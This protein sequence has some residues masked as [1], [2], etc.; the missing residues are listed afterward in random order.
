MALISL[1][2]MSS[3]TVLTHSIFWA[4]WIMQIQ[5]IQTKTL[6]ARHLTCI[7][8]ECTRPI[9]KAPSLCLLMAQRVTPSCG[10]NCAALGALGERVACPGY[11]LIAYARSDSMCEP[12]A[13]AVRAGAARLLSRLPSLGYAGPS[14][15]VRLHCLARCPGTA[16]TPANLC[17]RLCWAPTMRS[18]IHGLPAVGSGS[19]SCCA[20]AGCATRVRPCSVGA[21]CGCA[22]PGIAPLA[23][24]TAGGCTP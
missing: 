11:G 14:S 16:G 9:P 1:H 8:H 12:R 21:L 19:P 20:A 22:P 4:L 10:C 5:M 17:S 13:V 6:R 18:R 23:G 3:L 2:W 24:L 7:V 15:H